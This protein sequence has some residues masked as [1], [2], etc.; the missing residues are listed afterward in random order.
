M[1]NAI[2]LVNFYNKLDSCAS[3]LGKIKDL[4]AVSLGSFEQKK[5]AIQSKIKMEYDKGIVDSYILYY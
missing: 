3:I 4:Y 2:Q 1:N 5:Q